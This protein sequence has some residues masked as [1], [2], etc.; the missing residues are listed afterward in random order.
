MNLPASL[1]QLGDAEESEI[2]DDDLE[3]LGGGRR[4]F[5]VLDK[6]VLRLQVLVDDAFSMEVTQALLW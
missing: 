5:E 2:P 1:A 3:V 6:D 4:G